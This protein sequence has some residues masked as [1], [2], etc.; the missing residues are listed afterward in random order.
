MHVGGD[1]LVGEQHGCSGGEDDQ[2]QRQGGEREAVTTLEA[3]GQP[4]DDHAGNEQEHDVLILLDEREDDRIIPRTTDLVHHLLGSEPGFAV[5]GSRIKVTCRAEE[6]TGEGDEH[7]GLQYR[8]RIVY[9]TY[10]TVGIRTEAP[11]PADVPDRRTDPEDEYPH[12]NHINKRVRVVRELTRGNQADCQKEHEQITDMF[13]QGTPTLVNNHSHPIECTPDDEV[14]ACAVPQAADEH[15]EEGVAVGGKKFACGTPEQR[16]VAAERDIDISFQPSRERLM[17]ATP[18]L[19][20]V[21][22]F[23]RRVEVLRQVEAHEQRHAD[24]D[25]GVAGEVRI[26]LHRVREQG[27]EVLEA[28]EEHRALEHTVDEVDCKVVGE[29]DLLQ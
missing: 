5:G 7:E 6:Q 29:D 25:V 13:V 28:G 27:E 15:S 24:S 20:R 9:P 10:E 19:L 2:R 12:L 4:V 17:P 22:G 8:P 23:I 26:D 21:A 18:E 1:E 11:E 16:A 3:I 14:P